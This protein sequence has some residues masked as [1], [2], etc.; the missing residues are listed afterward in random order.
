MKHEEV[1]VV[2]RQALRC[3]DSDTTFRKQANIS[4]ISNLT[5]ILRR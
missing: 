5:L 1:Y 2:L 3:Y 4:Q